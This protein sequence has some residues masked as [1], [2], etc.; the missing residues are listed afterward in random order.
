MWARSELER[1][2]GFLVSDVARLLRRHF[3]RRLQSLGLTQ[4]QWRAIA[5]LARDEGLSQAA[6]A[7]RLEVKPI[8]LARLI[9]RVEAAGWVERQADPDDRR[10][11][12][13]YLTPQAAPILE[14]MRARAAETLEEAM[15][16]IS[17][18]ARDELVD[19]LWQM[20][21]N[22]SACDPAGR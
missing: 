6:L 13:L 5:H 1:G 3:D 10:V 12:R 7:E 4:A 17:G 16:G 18:R 19:V 11:S 21:Q 2:V 15:A 14:E 8:T 9:D 22:L 20:K